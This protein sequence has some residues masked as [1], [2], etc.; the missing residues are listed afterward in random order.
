VTWKSEST[1][2]RKVQFVDQQDRRAF[3]HRLQGAQEWT[4]HEVAL[5]E[6][7]GFERASVD[8]SARLGEADRHHLSC[9]V[10]FVH[11]ARD[12]ETLVALQANQLSPERLGKNLCDFGLADAGLALEEERP[13]QVECQEQ[14]G[15]ERSVGDVIGTAEQGER[16][17]D[18]ARERFQNGL[19]DGVQANAD[20]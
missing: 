1:S 10:P 13:C 14:D 9:V 16:L 20:G 12:I 17:V 4:A 2:R 3:R 11:R 8:A 19:L 7:I 18:R 15:G 5:G 6:E